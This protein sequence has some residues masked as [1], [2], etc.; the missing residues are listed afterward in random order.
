MTTKQF[1][2]GELLTAADVNQ[3]LVNDPEAL[4]D[5]FTELDEVK[6]Q[7]EE[8]ATSLE[9]MLQDIDPDNPPLV[10]FRL[11][12][13][14]YDWH[15]KIAKV[16]KEGHDGGFV[17][18]ISITFPDNMEIVDVITEPTCRPKFDMIDT[19]EKWGIAYN[20][21]TLT[22]QA[23]VYPNHDIPPLFRDVFII[24]KVVENA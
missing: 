11:D 13:M 6:T 22:T 2:P 7:V 18:N 5:F 19:N 16:E 1:K 15:K 17:T 21:N 23:K 24:L 14:S 4:Q 3:Y 8:L 9:P 20:R 12:V 10:G